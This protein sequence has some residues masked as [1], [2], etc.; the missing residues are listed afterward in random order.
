MKFGL[1]GKS[2]KHSYSKTI[3]ENFGFYE[4]DLCSVEENEI[5]GLLEKGEYGGFN[6][7]IPY[8]RTI[9]EYCSELSDEAR[10]IGS[11][12][13]IVKKPD[14]T[15]K[16][17][18]T[19]CGGFKYMVKKAGIEIGGRK[20]LI[21]GIG[22]ASAAV[23][24]ACED[25]GAGEIVFIS[26]SGRYNYENLEENEDG[27]ILIN[28]TPVGMFPNNGVMAADP[29]RFKSCKGVLDIV[30]NP[31]RPR[32]L[33]R[34]KELGIPC[35][36]GIDMLVAQ[37]AYASGYFIGAKIS[38]EEIEKACR[39]TVFDAE[40]IVITGMPG[41][42]KS[43][44]GKRIAKKL[45]REHIDTDSLITERTGMTIPKIFEKFGEKEF[46]RIETECVKDAAKLSGKV[47]STGGGV[48]LSEGNR[49][50]LCENGKIVLLKRDTEKLPTAGR[51]LSKDKATVLKLQK[52]R[53]PLYEAWADISIENNG[54]LSEIADRIKDTIINM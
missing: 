48:V 49:N 36:G 22:G 25:M 45:G 10:R 4:Y 20:V 15:Y 19:D 39:K 5:K 53:G 11:V 9:M 6:V 37:A 40:N 43:S 38:D 24:T 12:N 47:I 54:T 44:V 1:I 3:H 33:I 42:G 35:C 41:S 23:K 26:R 31:L 17:Y 32:F 18:N 8:K 21:F 30:Y 50:S 51:P 29:K 2:L 16:G 13:T 34:A 7:T 46:R 52:E 27:E 28:T 14:G